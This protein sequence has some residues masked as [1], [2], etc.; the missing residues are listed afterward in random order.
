MQQGFFADSSPMPKRDVNLDNAAVKKHREIIHLQANY[1][2][3][4]DIACTVEDSP[5]GLRIWEAALVEYMARGRNP[6]DVVEM[7]KSYK[8]MM[9]GIRV[10]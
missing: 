3:R 5:R 2:Q 1:I 7:L 9:D 6:K 10:G 4:E 8:A